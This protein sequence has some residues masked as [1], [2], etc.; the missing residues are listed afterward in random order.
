LANKEVLLEQKIIQ[1]INEQELFSPKTT[2]LLAVSGGADSVCLLHLLSNIHEEIN[3]ELQVAHLNHKL[4]GEESDDDAWYVADMANR[5]GIPFIMD[6]RDVAAYRD[7]KH[8]S[9]EE[10]A[11]EVRYSFLAAAALT[12]NANCVVTGHTRGDQVET[13]LMHLL[14]GTGITGL[15]GLKP[16]SVLFMGE[17]R[18][19]LTLI[20]PLLKASHQETM[21]YCRRFRLKPRSDSSNDSPVFFRNRVRLDLLPLLRAYNPQ[22]D[23]ALLRLAA[24]ASDHV[25][26]VEDLVSGLWNKVVQIENNMIYLDK[27]EL[28]S[29]PPTIQREIFRMAIEQMTG[30]LRDIQADH[31]E[32]MVGF[33]KKPAGKCLCLPHDLKLSVEY[34]RLVLALMGASS[35]HFP[36]MGNEIELNVPGETLLPG[37]KVTTKLIK[38]ALKSD[39]STFSACFD[40]DKTGRQLLVRGR[41]RGDRFQ[42]LGMGQIKKLQDFMVDERIPQTWRDRV[43]LLCSPQQICWVVGWRTDDSVKITEDTKEVV[44]I[45]FER[46]LHDCEFRP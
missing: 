27:L 24:I 3:V 37:W 12:I 16:K 34:N 14:R 10:A 9:L 19:P 20:R 43:P 18:K 35:C 36:A 23:T 25:S 7:Q 5:L 45:T 46:K 30:N 6:T 41:K 17:S 15:Q 39:K 32:D 4:R 22:V 2:L 21:S 26:F 38:K 40:L 42:P 31:I 33:L 1:F 28:L 13:I 8:C 29:Q 44:R 11:R